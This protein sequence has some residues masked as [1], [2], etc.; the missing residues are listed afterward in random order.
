MGL[1]DA[2]VGLLA[3]TIVTVTLAVTVL[4]AAEV[5]VIVIMLGEGAVDGAVYTP[6]ASIEPTPVVFEGTDQ[7]TFRH[8]L[9]KVVLQPGLLT[10][11]TN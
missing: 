3:V 1:T 8:V 7:F 5:A 9:L 4:S 10:V 6:L 2:T 11:A